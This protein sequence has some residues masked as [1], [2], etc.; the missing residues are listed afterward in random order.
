MQELKLYS[1]ITK[2]FRKRLKQ[3]K[4]KLFGIEAKQ[5]KLFSEIRDSQIP[6]R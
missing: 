1:P 5:V 2:K 3:H 4:N 6:V